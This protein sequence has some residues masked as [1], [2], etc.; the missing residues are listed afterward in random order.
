M[1]TNSCKYLS[2]ISHGESVVPVPIIIFYTLFVPETKLSFCPLWKKKKKKEKQNKQTI[3]H[4]TNF[5][6]IS[7]KLAGKLLVPRMRR[8]TRSNKTNLQTVSFFFLLYFHLLSFSFSIQSTVK[9]I[10]SIDTRK[11][12]TK[13][14]EGGKNQFCESGRADQSDNK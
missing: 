9:G 10:N 8:H 3:F 4:D 6:Q 2:I 5:Q 13:K 1:I 12:T 7:V 11:A 14:G